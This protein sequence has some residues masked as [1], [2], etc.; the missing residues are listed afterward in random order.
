MKKI[1]KILRKDNSFRLLSL[2]EV[3]KKKRMMNYALQPHKLSRKVKTE[4]DYFWLETVYCSYQNKVALE[5]RYE[6]VKNSEYDLWGWLS[7]QNRNVIVNQELTELR[8]ELPHFQDKKRTIYITFFDGKMNSFYNQEM[9]IFELSQYKRLYHTFT[10]QCIPITEYGIKPLKAGFSSAEVLYSK[11]E[12]LVLFHPEI[13]VF[14][15]V[16]NNEIFRFPFHKEK[17][18][19]WKKK[20]YTDLA[21][22]L[23]TLDKKQIITKI[24]E[25]EYCSDKVTK[26]LLHYLEKEKGV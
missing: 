20:D 7:Y 15:V 26:K 19:L 5:K 6:Y 4:L 23:V 8:K 1:E 12:D 3:Q 10:S 16:K 18:K 22:V 2:S 21:K 14:Y 25:K 9:A 11:E 24:V 17:V 13:N